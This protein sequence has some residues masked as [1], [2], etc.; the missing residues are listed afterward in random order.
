MNTEKEL[1]K[2]ILAYIKK[3]KLDSKSSHFKYIKSA[4]VREGL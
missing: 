1:L 4:I 2:N 3:Y